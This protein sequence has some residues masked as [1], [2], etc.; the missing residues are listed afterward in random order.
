LFALPAIC[1][2]DAKGSEHWALLNQVP[3]CNIWHKQPGREARMTSISTVGHA[4]ASAVPKAKSRNL[5]LDRART[6]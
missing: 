3:G 5:S 2:S 4:E 6:F 1:A